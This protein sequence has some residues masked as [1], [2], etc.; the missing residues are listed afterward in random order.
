VW[1]TALPGDRGDPRAL[2]GFRAENGLLVPDREFDEA[3]LVELDGREA[4][5]QP[6]EADELRL[7]TTTI[8]G[9]LLVVGAEGSDLDQDDLLALAASVERA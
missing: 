9:D 2:I 4:V 5:I 8:W 3:E 7:V 1:V 6:G